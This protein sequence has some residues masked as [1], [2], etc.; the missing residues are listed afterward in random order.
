MTDATL[1]ALLRD[2]LDAPDDDGARL[3]YADRLDELGEP[4]RAEFIRLDCLLWREWPDFSR[5]G[6]WERHFTEAGQ[7]LT[8]LERRIDEL[9]GADDGVC[10]RCDWHAPVPHV[11]WDWQIRRGFVEEVTCTAADWLTHADAIL[12]MHPVSEVW[13][14]KLNY[15]PLAATFRLYHSEY[16]AYYSSHRWPGLK[17]HLPALKPADLGLPD[18]LAG[19]PVVIETGYDPVMDGNPDVPK[20]QGVIGLK[21]KKG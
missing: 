9:S 16:G 19:L 21:S 11:G 8:A 17:F 12:A 1:A 15:H 14:T 2:V 5:A 13:L 18:T 6:N 20:P 10:L 4:E 3:R 7:K